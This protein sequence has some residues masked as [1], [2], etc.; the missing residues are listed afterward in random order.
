MPDLRT[1]LSE[2]NYNAAE[3]CFQALV[4]LHEPTGPVRVAADFRAPLNAPDEL[5]RQGLIQSAYSDLYAGRGM[6]A[7]LYGTTRRSTLSMRYYQ[8]CSSGCPRAPR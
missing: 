3:E 4:T 5:V 2:I 1:D 7:R 6:T 8:R